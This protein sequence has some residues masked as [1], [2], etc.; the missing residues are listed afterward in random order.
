MEKLGYKCFN[1]DLT[2]RYGFSFSVGGVYSNNK[3]TKFGIEGHGFH[4]CKN[5]EDTF[6]FF[7][8]ME[9]E[10][11]VCIVRGFGDI[12]SYDDE[13]YG[14]YDMYS[15]SNIEIIKKLSREE[16]FEYMLKSSKE[17][18]IRF[19][20]NYKLNDYELEVLNKKYLNDLDIINKIKYFQL[21]ENINL[22]KK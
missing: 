17:Q 15:S 12:V 9:E 16:I 18:L 14:Y 21:G 13:Y 5:L 19:I 3:E 11:C 4:F 6:R 10:V 1:K 7:P 8:A 20:K 2:N 22:Y